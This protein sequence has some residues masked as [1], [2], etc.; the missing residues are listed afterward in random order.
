MKLK[1]CVLVRSVSVYRRIMLSQTE[2]MVNKTHLKISVCGDSPQ[3]CRI[4]SQWRL[5]NCSFAPGWCQ[6]SNWR[7]VRSDRGI[8]NVKFSDYGKHA[9]RSNYSHM[10]VTDACL[11]V[12]YVP[13]DIWMNLFHCW[14][15]RTA[16]WTCTVGTHN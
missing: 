5:Q 10:L 1:F 16:K 6:C 15:H 7:A 13:P 8:K 14:H 2:Q 3:I 9:H 12:N 4:Q 11:R